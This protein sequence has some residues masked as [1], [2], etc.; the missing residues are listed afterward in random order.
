MSDIS[1][2]KSNDNDNSLL[3]RTVTNLVAVHEK[4]SAIKI[5]AGDIN[6]DLDDVEALITAT[7]VILTS[8]DGALS[9][10]ATE[11]TLSSID[12]KD[13]AT[14]TTLAAIDTSAS[15]IESSNNAINTRLGTNGDIA[16]ST[17]SES[18]QLRAIADKLDAL[19]TATGAA[20]DNAGDPTV[21]GILKAID[22][23][24]P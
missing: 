21:I 7:N 17:G 6:I 2:P 16:S 4:L 15:A 20:G 5:D 14:Q 19:I 18:A 8:I 24:N 3:R 23:D 13:F 10:V 9:D 22:A 12:G 1:L 11:T